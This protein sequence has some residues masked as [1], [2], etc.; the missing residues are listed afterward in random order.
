MFE[1]WE[2][3]VRT[4]WG[5]RF[6]DRV[7]LLGAELTDPSSNNIYPFDTRPPN[8]YVPHLRI[9]NVKIQPQTTRQFFETSNQLERLMSPPAQ[10]HVIIYGDDAHTLCFHQATPISVRWHNEEFDSVWAEVSF[11][12][13]NLRT[14]FVE[15]EQEWLRQTILARAELLRQDIE[16][17]YHENENE[18]QNLDWHKLGF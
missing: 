18:S 2:L 1:G 10:C 3:E 12:Y 6:T 11:Y 14:D 4:D 16:Q 13:Q 15:L 7:R 5:H 8:L 17:R 9:L